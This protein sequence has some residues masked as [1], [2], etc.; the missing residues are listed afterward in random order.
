[1]RLPRWLPWLVGVAIAV[2]TFHVWWELRKEQTRAVAALTQA[3]VEAVVTRLSGQVGSR[4]RTLERM[5]Q[6]WGEWR[7]VQP[8]KWE[9]DAALAY[10]PSTFVGIEWVDPGFRVRWAV[11]K[12]HFER[13]RGRDLAFERR[14][15]EALQEAR[16]L[17]AVRL[18]LP[19]ELLSGGKG[20]RAF[21]PA[22]DGSQLVGYISGAF[23]AQELFD[24]VLEGIAPNYGVTIYD[25]NEE[26]YRRSLQGAPPDEERS[27]EGTARV[28]NA[29]WRVRVWP[30]PTVVEHERTALPEVV[31]AA[32]LLT[33]LAIPLMMVLAQSAR[34][35]AA[36][37]GAANRRLAEEMSERAQLEEQMRQAQKME[38]I[39]RLTGGI[40]HDFNNLLGVILGFADLALEDPALSPAQRKHIEEIRK[41]G[42][43]AADLT[44]QL[45]AF[46]RKQLL[47]PRVFDI[48]TAV[49]ET[50]GL[51]RRLVGE[52]IELVT[53]LG[54]DA[55]NV[56]ADPTQIE[57]IILNL[58]ANARDAMPQGGKLTIETARVELDEAYARSHATV[59][60]GPYVLLAISD[61][62]QGMDPAVLPHVFEPFF[63]TK[64]LGKGTGLGLATVYGIV[65][66]SG[67]AIWV[68]G[69]PSHGTTFK[70][71]LP[72]IEE[73]TEV[74][75]GAAVA[76][77]TRGSETILLVED[78][79]TLR[80]VIAEFLQ[81]G[82]YRVLEAE[83]PVRASEI[84]RQHSSTIHLLLTDVVLPGTS[85]PV[86]ARELVTLHP[87]LKTLF[88][89]GYTDNTV[90]HHGALDA[91]LAFLQKPFTRLR[92]LQVVRQVLDATKAT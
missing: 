56:K 60:P 78:D 30:S 19:I 34:D 35:R 72:R 69:E 38:A 64:G 48:N 87:E 4:I 45:L 52:N 55:G 91:G 42:E 5:A 80:G 43:R 57:Q 17:H 73:P 86:L 84:A 75:A 33:S 49:R 76:V 89:S 83:T 15:S 66:Q 16:Q 40:A 68:Y 59:V 46:S 53:S 31:L 65:K 22:F 6:R 32:G 28:A 44:R 41:A 90:V 77:P 9:H 58:A 85:G 23:D 63:T 92:L 8:S 3:Q 29:T 79:T 20:F 36:E 13:T 81:R 24:A 70:I 18:T 2:T 37:L 11:P 10:E 39:G 82:G 26:L 54:A 7:Q 25:G 71:Y 74:V 21:A 88:I 67:G 51:L 14:R 47:E 12:E 27:R 62:G 61:T 1:M 50:E